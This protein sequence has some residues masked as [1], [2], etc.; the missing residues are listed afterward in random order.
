[1]I[2][3]KLLIICSA[4]ALMYGEFVFAND[5]EYTDESAELQESPKSQDYR[6]FGTKDQWQ[7]FFESQ[8]EPQQLFFVSK[9]EAEAIRKRKREKMDFLIKQLESLKSEDDIT[10]LT[11][12]LKKLKIENEDATGKLID[13]EDEST[14]DIP[15]APKETRSYNSERRESSSSVE[16]IKDAVARERAVASAASAAQRRYRSKLKKGS[17]GAYNAMR[18]NIAR[19]RNARE[20]NRAK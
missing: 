14:E 11:N 12:K 10:L 20:T 9:K 18:K 5:S 6:S 13:I 8:G 17:S 7:A 19:Q 4:V 1:M 2:M 16:E 15:P 3:S